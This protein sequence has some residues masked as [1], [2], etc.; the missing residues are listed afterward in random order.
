MTIVLL[1]SGDKTSLKQ[2]LAI[3]DAGP[4]TTLELRYGDPTKA[5]ATFNLAAPFA[6]PAEVI[7]EENG[8]RRLKNLPEIR[9]DV[10]SGTQALEDRWR[11]MVTRISTASV[12]LGADGKFA[13]A[14]A[15]NAAHT[16]FELLVG[17]GPDGTG[18]FGH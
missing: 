2:E 16:A 17:K 18:S 4:A 12:I 14:I 13:G 3:D 8:V 15:D 5:K 7:E 6:V 9:D 1:Q 10:A 11:D